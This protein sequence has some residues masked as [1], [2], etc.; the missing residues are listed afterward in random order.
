M[1][2]DEKADLV[3]TFVRVLFVNGQR[4]DQVMIAAERVARKLGMSAHLSMR[5]GDLQLQVEEDGV[6]RTL[7]V[8]ADPMG[9]DMHR[10]AAAFRVLGDL[11]ADRLTPAAALKTILAVAKM[12][13]ADTWRVAMAAG[14]GALALSVVYGLDQWPAAVLIFLSAALGAVVR[15]RAATFSPNALL[16]PF[17]AALL[18]GIV[19]ALA[20]RCDVSSSLRLVAIC[21]CMILVPGP[22]LLNAAFDL[23][24]GR[25]N[26][27]ASRLLFAGLV[28]AAIATGLLLGMGLLGVT[29]PADAPGRVVPIWQDMIAAGVAVASFCTFFSL[30]ARAMAWPVAIGMIA[31]GVRWLA[32][33]VFGFGVASGALVACITAALLVSPVARRLQIPFAA[34]SFASVVSIMPGIYFFRF[35]SGLE[36]IAA[37]Q[38]ATVELIGS[39]VA[40]GTTAF[41]IIAAMGLGLVIPKR[42]L[43]RF[44]I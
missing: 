34:M 12:P 21:P 8:A 14:G 7:H 19:G 17:A 1:T 20:V 15:R 6:A 41:M 38:H 43:D 32:M 9:V 40:D 26:L 18:A 35:G 4:S 31:H 37:G 22:H 10:V 39:V 13:S 28:I 36:Q 25:I 24:D 3:L 16:Q 11:E 5:W 29:I 33:T 44:G 27:G 42:I 2:L 23:L 30:P